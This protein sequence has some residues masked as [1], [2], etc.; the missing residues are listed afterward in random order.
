MA[1]SWA[2]PAL[3]CPLCDSETGQQVRAGIFD[4]QFG[5]NA[6]VTG[7]P[8]PILLAIVA[9]IHFGWPWSKGAP[10]QAVATAGSVS[11]G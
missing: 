8:F 2:S 11:D 1:A 7:L 9:L 4:A 3:A 5:Y 10:H 6:L